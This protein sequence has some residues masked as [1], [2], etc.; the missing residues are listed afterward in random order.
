MKKDKGDKGDK[1][2]LIEVS[3]FLTLF[4]HLY[5]PNLLFVPVFYQIPSSMSNC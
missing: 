5:L 4:S 3:I 2:D 1:G